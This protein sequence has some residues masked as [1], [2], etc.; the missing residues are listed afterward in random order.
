M[1]AH[2]KEEMWVIGMY[3][4]NGNIGISGTDQEDKN[5]AIDS[6]SRITF[7]KDYQ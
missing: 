4:V 3:V 2:R 6:V 7:L 1:L 5:K